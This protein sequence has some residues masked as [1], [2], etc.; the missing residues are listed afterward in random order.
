MNKKK[1]HIPHFKNEDAE[2]D[3]WAN[4]D[5]SEYFSAADFTT[6][7]FPNLKP[8]SHLVSMRVPDFLMMRLKEKANELNIPYSSLIKKYISQGL[9]F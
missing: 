1:L 9:G 5:L 7:S 3:F 6:V 4:T 8:S 2:R